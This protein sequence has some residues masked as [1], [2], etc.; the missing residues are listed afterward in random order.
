M[1]IRYY[2][3]ALLGFFTCLADATALEIDQPSVTFGVFGSLGID[4][5]SMGSGDYVVDG[6]IPKGSSL[7]QNWSPTNDTRIAGHMAAQYSPKVSVVLQV[8]S[9]YHTGNSYEPEVEF[10]NVKYA[11]TPDVYLRVGRVALPTFLESEN[12][13]V[14]YT[15]AWVHP[16]V[17]V[18]RQESITHSDGIDVN[19]RLQIGDAGNNFKALFGRSTGEIGD[20]M[21]SLSFTSEHL[22]GIFDTIEYGSTIVHIGYQQRETDSGYYLTGQPGLS[23][24]D[25][26]LSAGIKYDPGNWFAMSEWIQRES[27]YK[28]NAMYVSGGYR[29]NKYTPY[30]TYANSSQGS[31]MPGFPPPSPEGVVLAN[32]AQS[33]YSLGVRWDFMRD[34]DFKLQL[35]RVKLGDNSNGFLANVPAGVD[36]SGQTFHVISAVLDFIF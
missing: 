24:E 5:S 16:P 11:F 31:F 34:T 2:L 1:A 17:E 8:D 15:Y 18:Y 3:I 22:W 10:A 28:V 21:S 9:E 25:S 14:G 29:I 35:D 7:S 33:T 26:D 20:S 4:H 30:L 12:R 13:D 23:V 32:R 6:G 36:L 27:T 19:Y